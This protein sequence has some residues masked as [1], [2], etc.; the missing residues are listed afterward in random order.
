MEINIDNEKSRE[1]INKIIQHSSRDYKYNDRHIN[2]TEVV[3]T[4]CLREAWFKRKKG[5]K[6]FDGERVNIA[7]WR[8]SVFDA[9]MNRLMEEH[10]LQT[11]VHI[12]IPIPERRVTLSGYADWYD[13]KENAVYEFKTIVSNYYLKEGAKPDHIAQVLAYAYALSAEKAYIV[14]F[15]MGDFLTFNIPVYPAIL[16]ENIRKMKKRAI[17][18]HDALVADKPPAAEPS[19]RCRSCPFRDVCQEVIE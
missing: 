10:G 13:P 2:I 11:Q 17:I 7:L 16:E 6:E 9:E 12:T 18:L 5:F 1:I 19:W 14:Y 4:A 8:G 3:P 15:D